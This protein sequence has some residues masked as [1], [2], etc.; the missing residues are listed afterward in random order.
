MDT[1]SSVL[2]F[3]GLLLRVSVA[4]PAHSWD[5][6]DLSMAS[7]VV[8][9]GESAE[10][11]CMLKESNVAY[12][13]LKGGS[14]ENSTVVASF[15]SGRPTNDPDEPFTVTENGTLIIKTVSRTDEGK[16]ICRV[17]SK[18]ISCHGEVFVFVQAALQDFQLTIEYCEPEN[19]C[20]ISTE[21]TK[22]TSLTC[23][24]T[25]ASP[26]MKLKWFNGSREIKVN[27]EENSLTKETPR[28]ISSTIKDVYKA[29]STLTC[30][31]VDF[32]TSNDDGMF[33]H[34]QFRTPASTADISPGWTVTAILFIVGFVIVFL[35]VI[36]FTV[37]PK[38]R[39]GKDVETQN[40]P[41]QVSL[42]R[43]KQDLTNKIAELEK[44]LDT[45]KKDLSNKNEENQEQKDNF[46][47][48]LLEIQQL[49]SE[50]KHLKEQ[51]TEKQTSLG[52]VTGNLSRTN[53]E[54]QKQ[55]DILAKKDLKIQ[56]LQ[57]ELTHVKEPLTKIQKSEQEVSSKQNKLTERETN[58]MKSEQEVSS[59]ERRLTEREA[60]LMKSEQEVCS[61]QNKLT[62]R[63]ANLMKSEQEVSSKERRLTER[64]T[65]L[66]TREQQH[67]SK[68][69][70]LIADMKSHDNDMNS[71]VSKLKEQ[72]KDQLLRIERKRREF[73]LDQ[74]SA[75]DPVRINCRVITSRG[76]EDTRVATQEISG[77][78]T[79]KTKSKLWF[80]SKD[81]KF[82]RIY[83]ASEK[84]IDL[85]QS[86]V[87]LVENAI[88][89]KYSC[90]IANDFIGREHWKTMFG[91]DD[92]ASD[93][94]VPFVVTKIFER[95][96]ELTA[97]DYEVD[98][99]ARFLFGM[100]MLKPSA[101]TLP[102]FADA[103]DKGASFA[104]IKSVPKVAI[105]DEEKALEL[106]KQ[107]R[108]KYGIVDV[109]TEHFVQF[110]IQTKRNKETHAG[111][112]LLGTFGGVRVVKE[113]F[114]LV[115]PS[116]PVTKT[117]SDFIFDDRCRS[118][119]ITHI[120]Q[121]QVSEANDCLA[122]V[123]EIGKKTKK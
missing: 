27:I 111:V 36:F 11:S 85:C 56:Q 42:L 122:I 24:A 26:S 93:A 28:E 63:E 96:K 94:L 68:E 72:E 80:Q 30:Q 100:Y 39:N 70:K 123:K 89:G 99:Q 86:I 82:H 18:E 5:E 98:V 76:S 66:M 33:A 62:E 83:S 67:S 2:F 46:T 95:T 10:I 19:S 21:S 4:V 103:L 47:K 90:L 20:V 6:S 108:G 120:H 43:S 75:K 88:D 59:K 97:L 114:C 61:K 53:E 57:S 79:V 81:A 31:A 13:W 58:L 112:L 69:K 74:I 104:N 52:T 109:D 60:N 55:K 38:V 35:F 115:D 65:N 91:P 1:S 9:E 117:I 16:Y 41:E 14:L 71:K 48:K 101:S 121:D 84:S 73:R 7:V 102:S 15:I 23:K 49:K 40:S 25:N 92:G 54:N 29:S 34:V 45:V 105:E 12:F 110:Y 113:C 119:L 17:S 64:E 50:L 116:S 37:W 78:A 44:S 32:K 77:Q 107:S 106:L 8:K 87:D 118:V 51:L 3:V 22:P